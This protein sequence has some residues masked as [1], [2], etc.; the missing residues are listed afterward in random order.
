M[1][2][3]YT[4]ELPFAIDSYVYKIIKDK[5]IKHPHR[6]WVA[7]Y[8]IP[9]DN[10]FSTIHIAHY[11]GSTLDYSEEINLADAMKLLFRNESDAEEAMRKL[12]DED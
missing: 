12:Q 6:C 11:I 3:N 9:A 10:R 4:I 1:E 7:G 5:R 2:E 8:W